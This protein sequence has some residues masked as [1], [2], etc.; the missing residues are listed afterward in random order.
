[1][2]IVE[3]TMQYLFKKVMGKDLETPFRRIPWMEAVERYG[4]DKPDLRFGAVLR[5]MSEEVSRMLN[6]SE[7]EVARA[8]TI[9]L[10]SSK[11]RKHLKLVKRMVKDLN[12]A[13]KVSKFAYVARVGGAVASNLGSE[14]SEEAAKAF[15]L[16]EGEVVIIA[17]GS[18]LKVSEALGDLRNALGRTLE[19]AKLGEYVFTWII[20]FTLFELDE[21]IWL[22]VP[23]RHHSLPQRLKTYLSLMK[24]CSP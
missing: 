16:G 15:S 18:Y 19:I 22:G 1:M 13:N 11:L 7:D 12:E 6:V 21:E 2:S 17:A 9:N 20:D 10:P 23:G 5:T 14:A 3:G 24:T 8:L 4:T